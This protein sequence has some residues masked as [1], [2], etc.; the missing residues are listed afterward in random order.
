MSTTLAQ[1][2]ADPPRRRSSTIVVRPSTDA[3]S[4]WST[5][6]WR[7]PLARTSN[8]PR[9]LLA[10]SRNA[11]EFPVSTIVYTQPRNSAATKS[12]FLFSLSLSLSL[13]QTHTHTHAHTVCRLIRTRST[14]HPTSHSSTF[15]PFPSLFLSISISTSISLRDRVRNSVS[16]GLGDVVERVTFTRRWPRRRS[17]SDGQSARGYAIDRSLPPQV[18]EDR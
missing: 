8:A 2:S 18:R 4:Y 14:S 10:A 5:V 12:R 3:D 6:A 7:T 11:F 13:S 16:L 1:I 9:T 17:G 15:R